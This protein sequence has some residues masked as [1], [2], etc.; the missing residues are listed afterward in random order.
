MVEPGTPALKKIVEH[1]G[2]DILLPDGYLNRPKLGS[3][4]FN[5]ELQRKKLNSI[6]HPAVWRAMFWAV[7]SYWIRGERLCIMDTP[8]L[9]EGGLW[10]WVGK[11]VVVYWYASSSQSF[12]AYIDSLHQ[13][14]GDSAAEVDEARR[15]KYGERVVSIK[16]TNAHY[17][18]ATV[19]GHRRR[20]LRL[21]AGPPNP[22]RFSRAP[23]AY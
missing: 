14:S 8:L 18:K 21:P 3:I 4:I 13:L 11:I 15:F 12:R 9:I 1:F 22:G 20:Q 10:K 5:D 16:V 17:R 6:V 7:C 19:R 2:E 23:T